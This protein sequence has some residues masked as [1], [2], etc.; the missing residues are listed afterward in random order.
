MTDTSGYHKKSLSRRSDG[1][2][3]RTIGKAYNAHGQ[4]KPKRFL[5]GK[6]EHQAR[7]ASALLEALWPAVVADFEQRRSD[8]LKLLDAGGDLRESPQDPTPITPKDVERWEPCWDEETLPIGEAARQGLR[9]AFIASGPDESPADYATRLHDLSQRFPDYSFNAPTED[10]RKRLTQGIHAHQHNLDAMTDQIQTMA[11]ISKKPR[12]ALLG[13][14][15]YQA[16]RAFANDMQAKPGS[17]ATKVAERARRLMD[18]TPD[19]DLG[20][21]GLKSMERIATYWA[22]RPEARKRGG[23]GKGTPISIS[24]VEHQLA[25]ARRFIKWLDRHED[26]A[27]QMPRHSEDSLKVNLQRLQTPGEIAAKR[28]GVQTFSVEQLAKIYQHANDE[29]RLWILLGLNAGFSHAECLSLRWEEIEDDSSWIKRI[30]QKSQVYGEFKLWPQTQSALQWWEQSNGRVHDLVLAHSENQT[31]SSIRIRNA[32][33]RLKEHVPDSGDWWLSFKHLRK[34]AAQM[35]RDVSNGEIAGVFLCHGKPVQSDELSDLY[36]NRP[37]GEVG[38]A[39]DTVH[40]QLKPVFDAAPH[41][42][43]NDA[44]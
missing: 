20:Q 33:N 6:D 31:Y 18:S 16:I 38:K 26:F 22:G 28:N 27:W 7:L 3:H 5:L 24:T 29:N 4:L 41:A 42:F 15:L 8:Y 37:F 35:V 40:K 1:Q 23:E 30:R 36:S 2:Y 34:T 13:A 10:D 11:D 9:T 44:S 43:S 32:W 17:G 25:T 21:F 39:L 14:S 19:M 12:P